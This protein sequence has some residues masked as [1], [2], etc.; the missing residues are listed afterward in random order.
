M[1]EFASKWQSKPA[2]SG[3]GERVKDAFKGPA[4]MNASFT[5]SPSP[6]VAGFCHL[7]ANSDILS[8]VLN[9]FD[10]VFYRRCIAIIGHCSDR[11]YGDM[12]EDALKFNAGLE[13]FGLSDYEARAYTALLLHDP[14]L[15][16]ELAYHAQ[17][18]RTK[19]YAAVDRHPDTTL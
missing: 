13:S 7:D 9:L 16:S 1:S 2:T 5:R 10:S 15:I 11:G 19:T 8:T 4:G 14:L 3:L 18:P 12:G 6:L 17:I